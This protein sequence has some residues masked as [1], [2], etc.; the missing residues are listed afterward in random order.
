MIMKIFLGLFLTALAGVTLWLMVYAT[1]CLFDC[2]EQFINLT[3]YKFHTNKYKENKPCITFSQFIAFYNVAPEK[4]GIT[5]EYTVYYKPDQY[6]CPA[7]IGFATHGDRYKYLCW[8]KKQMKYRQALRQNSQMDA[9]VK[10]WRKDTVA[11]QQ[12]VYNEANKAYETI[13]QNMI[14]EK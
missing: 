7:E 13:L 5:S 11:Y 8:R 4:W 1:C 2:G 3:L 12:K 9:L 10:E 6:S 14:K